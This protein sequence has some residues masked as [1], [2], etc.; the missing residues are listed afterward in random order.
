MNLL[1]L[2]LENLD[3]QELK[4]ELKNI[5]PMQLICN[6]EVT[7]EV[8]KITYEYDTTRGNHRDNAEKTM[9]KEKPIN[10]NSKRVSDESMK[11]FKENNVKQDF[12]NYIKNFN[13]ENPK[14]AL[15]NVK[16]LSVVSLG[17]SRLI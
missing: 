12:I 13:N 7:F 1:N 9:V 16:I 17:E 2:I 3:N 11:L 15:F 5:H 8:Y 14:R 6:E 4:Q 10:K